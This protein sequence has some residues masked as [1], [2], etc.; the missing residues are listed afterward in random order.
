[1][2]SNQLKIKVCGMRNAQNV[3]EVAALMPTYMGFVF[4]PKSP[5]YAA[6][7]S[8]QTVRDIPHEITP[9]AVFVNENME[10]MLSVCAEYGIST[11]QLHGQESPSACNALRNNGLTV[12]KAAAL[13]SAD[14]IAAL[15]QYVGTVDMFVFDTKTADGTNGGSGRKWDWSLLD[16]YKLPVTYLLSGGIGPDDVQKIAYAQR[17]G[18]VGID[19]NSRFETS[20]GMKDVQ[21]LTQFF[22]TIQQ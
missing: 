10:R 5:R 15:Q 16:N 11:V 1:M 13:T 2:Q 17:P 6:V 21:L 8:A 9:V 3:A 7:L 22:K 14:D 4:Y 12:F 19:I 18:M 20:P